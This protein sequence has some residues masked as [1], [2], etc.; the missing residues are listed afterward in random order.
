MRL[1]IIEDLITEIISDMRHVDKEYKALTSTD[2]WIKGSEDWTNY[3]KTFHTANVKNR[4][5]IY[6]DILKRI[7][8]LKTR[9]EVD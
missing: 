4:L 6:S 9:Y 2:E 1:E 5:E 7:K 3:S 8:T